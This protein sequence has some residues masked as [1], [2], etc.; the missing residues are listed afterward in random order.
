MDFA[1]GI[2]DKNFIFLE[3]RLEIKV[4]R[5]NTAKWET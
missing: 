3:L 5:S 1:E 2:L 4:G